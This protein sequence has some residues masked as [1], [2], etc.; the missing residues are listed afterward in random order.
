VLLFFTIKFIL[1]L[2]TTCSIFADGTHYKTEGL[3]IGRYER[4]EMKPSIETTTNM[5]KILEVSLD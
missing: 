4:D 5:A 1:I 2:Q 3:V